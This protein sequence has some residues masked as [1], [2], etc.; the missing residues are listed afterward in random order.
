MRAHLPRDIIVYIQC[1][2]LKA[3]LPMCSASLE[4]KKVNIRWKKAGKI[5]RSLTK[6]LETCKYTMLF[7]HGICLIECF[8]EELWNLKLELLV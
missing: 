7:S 1:Q 4:E 6:L 2:K 3:H 8:S 5:I